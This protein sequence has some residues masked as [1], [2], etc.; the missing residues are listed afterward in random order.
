MFSI[1]SAT[2]ITQTLTCPFLNMKFYLSRTAFLFVILTLRTVL[3]VSVPFICL[4]LNYL[5]PFSPRGFFALT[6]KKAFP[7][8]TN[9]LQLIISVLT[10]LLVPIL[11]KFVSPM[12]CP[13]HFQ[14]SSVD[15]HFQ[16]SF[17]FFFKKLSNIH[18]RK[19]LDIIIT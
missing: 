10:F 4:K 12:L 7:R 9:K 18:S 6:L 16:V 8:V 14:H 13:C 5:P 15:V 2:T 11:H 17:S 1:E 3:V 19:R